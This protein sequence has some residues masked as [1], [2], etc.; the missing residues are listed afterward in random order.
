MKRALA[1]EWARARSLRSTW[2]LL[3]ASGVLQFASGLHWGLRRDPGAFV[4]ASGVAGKLGAVLVA[5]IGVA[6]F[7]A[8]HQHGTLA[9]TRLVLRSPSRIVAARALVTAGLGGLG[10]VAMVV[11]TAAGVAAGGGA[12]PAGEGAAGRAAGAVV[13]L[14][15]LSGLA[16]VALGGLLRHSGLAIGVFAGWAFVVELVLGVVAGVPAT[17]LPFTGTALFAAPG[18][19]AFAGLVAVAL[20]AAAVGTARGGSLG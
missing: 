5:A 19:G 11:L 18:I 15:V 20:T 3:T 12:L 8:D 17:V 10:G 14:T 1:Y 7:G 4:A 16:G 6:S 13:L 2:L 9:T